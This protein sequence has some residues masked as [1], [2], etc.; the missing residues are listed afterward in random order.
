MLILLLC[1]LLVVADEGRLTVPLYNWPHSMWG[2][3][4]RLHHLAQGS[5]QLHSDKSQKQPTMMDS[6]GSHCYRAALLSGSRVMV[7]C[8]FT[9]A[10]LVLWNGNDLFKWWEQMWSFFFFFHDCVMVF[11][12][13]P[14][15]LMYKNRDRKGFLVKCDFLIGRQNHF[16]NQ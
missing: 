3:S 4:K 13:L 10:N 8:S 14:D 7:L 16:C 15:A 6:D 11:A 2:K 5:P 9:C 1:W 12:H